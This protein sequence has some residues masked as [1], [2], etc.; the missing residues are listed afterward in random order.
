MAH[1]QIKNLPDDMHEELRRRAGQRSLSLRDYVISVLRQDISR[2]TVQDW[3]EE[4]HG[5]E[6]VGTAIDSVG[7]IS[8]ARVERDAEADAR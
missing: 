6:P 7:V 2:P 5:D 3:L 4:L 8:D 1:L